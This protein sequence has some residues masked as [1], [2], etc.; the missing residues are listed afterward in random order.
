[1]FTVVQIPD[2]L[3]QGYDYM[4][5]NLASHT[6]GATFMLSLLAYSMMKAACYVLFLAF[7]I[8]FV[9]RAYWVGLVGLLA[10]YPTGIQY[11]RLPLSTTYSRRRMEEQLGSLNRY[12]LRLDQ[13]CSVI[14]A[15]AFL[16]VIMFILVS[17]VYLL[18]ILIYVVLQPLLP[19]AVWAGLQTAGTVL[20]FVWLGAVLI[21]NLRKVRQ[22]P[23]G[24]RLHYQLQAMS[25]LA[26]IGLYKPYAYIIN[27]FYSQLPRRKVVQTTA[28]TSTVFFLI[29]MVE[30]V[31]DVLAA[32]GGRNLFAQRHLFTASVDEKFVNPNGYD[33]LRSED[34]L[35]EKASIQSDVV[36]EPFVRLF[37][38]Y[39][40]SLDTLLKSA[41]VEPVWSD[42]LSREERQQ[43]IADWSST[44]INRLIRVS[45]DDSTFQDSGFLF[46]ERGSSQQRGFQAVLPIGELKAGNHLLHVL[47]APKPTG[48]PEALMSIPFWYMPEK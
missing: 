12:I 19:P 39:P 42:S 23:V 48:K 27:T 33:N 32:K 38:A 36:R 1:M 18:L 10:V 6:E 22:H 28:I 37:I 15:I 29:L 41:A 20:Y 43:K 25:K 31:S 30:V 2:L 40:K 5:Y 17:I 9:M 3:T 14:F 4:A 45:V 16:I 11:D 13:R 47:V 35:I 24:E 21:L 8:N 34:E 26:F 46:T 7:L 44:Q